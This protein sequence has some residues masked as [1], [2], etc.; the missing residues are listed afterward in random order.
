MGP[1]LFG[2]FLYGWSETFINDEHY[3]FFIPIIGPI[4]GAI[5]GVWIYVGYIWIIN[6]YL[7]SHKHPI[8][9][10]LK[11]IELE[12]KKPLETRQKV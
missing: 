8:R 1:R 3:F 7:H 9:N 5:L 11:D 4:V 6:S 10:D 12:D 2:A